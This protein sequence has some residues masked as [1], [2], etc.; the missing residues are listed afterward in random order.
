VKDKG[1]WAIVDQS[2]NVVIQVDWYYCESF[3]HSFKEKQLIFY[4]AQIFS[5]LHW[6]SVCTII[7]S[8]CWYYIVLLLRWLRIY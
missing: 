2:N 6:L 3:Y 8:G 7:S 5:I 4:I 1:E